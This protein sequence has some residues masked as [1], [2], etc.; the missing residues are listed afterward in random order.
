MLL[1]MF[2]WVSSKLVCEVC[3][4]WNESKILADIQTSVHSD[5]SGC[6]RQ[7]HYLVCQFPACE[8]LHSTFSQGWDIYTFHIEHHEPSAGPVLYFP[9][10]LLDQNSAVWHTN[11]FSPW[12]HFYQQQSAWSQSQQLVF[13]KL[14]EVKAPW[15]SRCPRRQ[16]GLRCFSLVVPIVTVVDWHT[17]SPDQL[18]LTVNIW[19]WFG[20][21][22]EPGTFPSR[23]KW[24]MPSGSREK[25]ISGSVGMSYAGSPACRGSLWLEQG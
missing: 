8:D 10:V 18:A 14:R 6:L 5:C 23:K 4:I 15:S 1:L 21:Y 3:L 13:C 7:V 24:M 25:N 12:L 22:H 2:L 9:A 11:Q 19:A 20:V 17:A 16:S